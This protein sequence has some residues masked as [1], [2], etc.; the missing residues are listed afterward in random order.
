MAVRLRPMTII[1]YLRKQTRT[2]NTVKWVGVGVALVL[3]LIAV[4]TDQS[5]ATQY[6]W[7]LVPMVPA[8]ATMIF[9]G[10]RL[11]CPR[12]RAE[13]NQ[14]LLRSRDQVPLRFCPMCGADF[15]ELLPQDPIS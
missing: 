13:L 8:I 4:F 11:K 14:H 15:S 1:E 6:G 2:I 7:M 10:R 3:G 12:C 5:K 9:L